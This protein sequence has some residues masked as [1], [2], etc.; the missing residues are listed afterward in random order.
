VLYR[1]SLKIETGSFGSM[2]Q[3]V[4]PWVMIVAGVGIGVV[5]FVTIGSELATG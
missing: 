4:G 1:K 5:G 2:K 3:R